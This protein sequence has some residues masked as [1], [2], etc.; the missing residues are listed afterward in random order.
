MGKPLLSVI[1][2]TKDRY[3]YLKYLIELIASFKSEEVELVIQDNSDDNTDFVV[4]LNNLKYNFIKYDYTHGQIPMSENSDK[5]IL[6]STGEFV[7]F[8]GDDDGL[9]RYALN[10]ARWMKNNGV[11]AVK[12]STINYYWP[13]ISQGSQKKPTSVLKY[14]TFTGK[15]SN[16]SPLNELEKVLKKG[17][18]DRGRMPLVYHSIVRRD[19]L[20]KV[21]N[22][23]GTFFPGN[24][25]DIS[26][27]VALS[28]TVNK[29]AYIDFPLAFS[30]WSVFHGGGVHAT[31]KKGHPEINEVPWFRPNSDQNWD[32]RVPRVAAGAFI[33]AD[34]AISALNKMGAG[35][36]YKEINFNKMYASF[37]VNNPSYIQRVKDV[38]TDKIGYFMCYYFI[39]V[40]KY[41]DALCRRVGWSLGLIEK[42]KLE[43]NLNDIIQASRF[44]E[45]LA[46]D[47]PSVIKSE[48][49][50]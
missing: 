40:K 2:P 20:D 4:Y 32:K 19:V 44:L 16:L 18:T 15:V 14:N 9:T 39:T 47:V 42:P 13:D 30:G 23:V 8:L 28:L 29:Y 48:M 31:G 35:H 1:V 45:K 24:S 7:C 33:W 34:S 37:V 38:Y 3:K 27:A 26:N 12:S 43:K 5:A 6:N 10:C 46:K 25:P 17:I 49:I 21:Y 41:S 22:L 11:E 36:L 50:K